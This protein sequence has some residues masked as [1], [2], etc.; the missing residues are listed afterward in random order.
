M[1][2]EI[3]EYITFGD[4]NTKS[5]GWYLE[6]REAPAP[7]EKEV[8][9][10]LLYSQGVLDFSMM[11]DERYFNNRIITYEFKLPNTR[12]ADR[13]SAEREI[14]STLMRI[15]KSRLTDTHDEGF[16]WYGKCKSVKVQ[17]DPK[18][19]AL[20][21][22]I[23]FD[24]YPFLT[25]MDDYFDDVWDDFSFEYGVANWTKWE[26]KEKQVIPVFNPGDTTIIPRIIS[27]SNIVINFEGTD[28]QFS[29]GENESVLLKIPP[30][31]LAFFTIKG[32][33]D[34]S[35]RFPREVMG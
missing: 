7:E 4:F 5:H 22:T 21:A 9:E 24:C 23:E 26:I 32:N 1:I 31:K 13:K 33:A 8:L 34:V 11:N 30:R 17:D 10:N 15:G 2:L 25:A 6:S 12:Y 16:Y 27:S 28:Y 14:K 18:K 20:I 19:K 3:V 29:S 35:F